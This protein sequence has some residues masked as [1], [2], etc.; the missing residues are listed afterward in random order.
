MSIQNVAQIA[1]DNVTAIVISHGRDVGYVAETV[2]AVRSQSYLPSQIL[3]GIDSSVA[4]ANHGLDELDDIQILTHAGRNFGTAIDEV[5]AQVELNG[6]WLWLLHA[7]SAPEPEA[8]DRLLRVGENSRTTGVIGPKQVTWDSKGAKRQLLEVG[9]MAT[10]SARRVPEIDQNERDQGQLDSRTDVLA[11]GSAGMLVNREAWEKVGGFNPDF[12]PFGDGLEFSRRLRHAGYRVV[13][14]PTA[15]VRHARTSL[16]RELATSFGQRRAAQVRNALIAAP[17]SLVTLL[18]LGYIAAAIPRALVRLLFKEGHY[19]QGELSAGL[20]IMRSLPAVRR[21]RDAITEVAAVGREA[22]AE[23]ESAPADVRLAR[24]E[25]RRSRSEAKIMAELPD[26]LTI[27]AKADLRGHTRRGYIITA[28]SAF[29]FALVFFL[30]M[31]SHGALSGGALAA[32]TADAGTVWKAIFSG[33]QASGDGY[34]LPLDPLW[35]TFLP[36]LVLGM[37]VGLTV[38]QLATV[39]LYTA[40]PATALLAYY[41]LQ[42]FTLNWAVRT[43]VALLWMVA[44]PF[45]SALNE[46]RLGAVIA[47][48]L[49]PLF[50]YSL[51]GAWKG[52]KNNAGLAALILALL[53]AA[54]PG[55]ALIGAGLGLFGLLTRRGMRLRWVLIVLPAL[56]LH[57]PVIRHLTREEILNY[58]FA[59]PGVPLA[60]EGEPLRVLTF[61]M[62]EEFTTNPALNWLAFIP[63]A[64][65][66]VAAVFALLREEHMWIIRAAWLMIIGGMLWAVFA[67]QVSVG[68]TSGMESVEVTAWPGYGLSLAWAGLMVAIA[69]GSYALRTS[70]QGR[71][72]GPAQIISGLLIALIPVGTLTLLG[73]GLFTVLTDEERPLAGINPMML[74]AVGIEDQSRN[75]RVLAVDATDQGIEA[76][77]WRGYGIELTEYSMLGNIR[78]LTQPSDAAH[79]HL[80][81]SIANLTSGSQRA[82]AM[83]GE[84]AV[85]V[86]LVPAA[87]EGSSR[88]YRNELIAQLNAVPGL[89]YVSSNE[90]GDFWRVE[91]NRGLPAR[92]RIADAEQLPAG[93]YG[94]NTPIDGAETGREVVLAERAD[95]GWR[96]SVNGTA[97]VPV[98]KDQ[99][100]QTWTLPANLAGELEIKYVDPLHLG[101]AITQ[102][103]MLT[104]ALL[105]ALPLRRR[106]GRSE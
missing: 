34:H 75:L 28:I 90:A 103:L 82:A 74:P 73:Y 58:L 24:R 95:A 16:G 89:N 22:V 36:L 100:A 65:I 66:V 8:L 80:A 41:A 56:A 102:T 62:G 96:A 92:A 86:V 9:I 61:V 26:P 98:E 94:V 23:L 39:V 106:T 37:P 47:H 31:L 49:L 15:I 33:W 77:L 83:I 59:A 67:T 44:P 43:L 42:R 27:K 19:A 85:S 55:Y 20:D 53:S 3:V 69:A 5:L 38:S 21:G 60:A 91:V 6:Q 64:V 87:D 105:A 12:G 32:S 48:T 13:V 72:F 4:S 29:V 11:V 97:L 40:L 1:R 68:R 14:E 54:A 88:T 30:P 25:L 46:G 10:R 99:W 17:A 101:L 51:V 76:Q 50:V 63:I 52:S 45:L 78:A 79:E 70:L 93:V 81:E 84:H 57:A 71:A 35:I 104:F 18:W 2:R 7:D